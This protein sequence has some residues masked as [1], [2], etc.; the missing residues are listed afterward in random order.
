MKTAMIMR[1]AKAVTASPGMT[2]H[3]RPLDERGI[4]DAERMARWLARRNDPPDTIIASSSLRTR[5]TADL[6]AEHLPFPGEILIQPRL[7]H[8]TADTWRRTL[9]ELPDV[10]DCILAIGHNPGIEELISQAAGQSIRM[11]TAAVAVLVAP[12]DRWQD[13]TPETSLSLD[14]M[15]WPKGEQM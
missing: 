5:Q 10:I 2:D 1:H 15:W 12:I 11:P 14:A 6:V 9:A 13:L 7:Y 3:D 8:C 4:A